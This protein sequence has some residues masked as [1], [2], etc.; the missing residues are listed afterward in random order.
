MERKARV[1]AM[2]VTS[3]R[4]CSHCSF[5]SQHSSLS[6]HASHRPPPTTF[7]RARVDNPSPTP[8]PHRALNGLADPS[9]EFPKSLVWK[10]VDSV[11]LFGRVGSICMCNWVNI[12]PVCLSS[13]L[14]GI[15]G[16]VPRNLRTS[17]SIKEQTRIH[18]AASPCL[19]K[20]I[21]RV[22]AGGLPGAERKARDRSREMV[23]K[24]LTRR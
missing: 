7:H 18:E 3:L 11:A 17:T 4:R 20:S 8:H 21:Q 2:S 13:V 9:T 22:V 10:S 16:N 6:W 24:F 23:P 15:V 19:P 1:R 14:L 5:C 12:H